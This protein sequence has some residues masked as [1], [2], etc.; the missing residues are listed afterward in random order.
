[1]ANVWLGVP[2]NMI[3][4]T[5]GLMAIPEEMYEAARIDGANAWNRFRFITLPAM[6]ASIATVLSL[7]IIFTLQQF[8][9]F[10]AMTN[11]GPAGIEYGAA[12]LVVAVVVR[13][14]GDRQG[15]GGRVPGP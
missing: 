13:D 3:F 8:D 12:I 6:R 1:M 11:G 15:G 10:A 7:G 9:L 4:L 2:F 5:I 14:A